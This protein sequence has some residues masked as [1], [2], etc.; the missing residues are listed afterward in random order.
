MTAK[1]AN[2]LKTDSPG[3]KKRTVP[4]SAWKDG[5]SGNPAGRP[6]DGESWAGVISKVANM[7]TDEILEFVG[8]GTRM[9]KEIKKLPRNV[10]VKYLVTA[11]VLAE[12]MTKP[13]AGLWNGL[14][15]RM[16]GKV[17]LPVK[18]VGD[19]PLLVFESEPTD[20]KDSER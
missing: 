11:Q 16:D 7:T 19:L 9:G 12:L 4:K 8:A 18:N 5:Q 17:A 20:G 6:K 13:N 2:R 15:D 10:Q 3:K 14:M 1:S